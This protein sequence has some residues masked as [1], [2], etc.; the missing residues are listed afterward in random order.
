MALAFWVDSRPDGVAAAFAAHDEYLSIFSYF[1]NGQTKYMMTP[2]DQFYTAPFCYMPKSRKGGFIVFTCQV[3]WLHG[4]PL[5]ESE[6]AHHRAHEYMELKGKYDVP[7]LGTVEKFMT[8]LGLKERDIFTF[9]NDGCYPTKRDISEALED[10]AVE[11]TCAAMGWDI[12]QN[13]RIVRK[14]ESE[15]HGLPILNLADWDQKQRKNH[16][17]TNNNNDSDNASKKNASHADTTQVAQSKGD[18]KNNKQVNL[19]E[20]KKDSSTDEYQC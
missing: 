19:Q 17:H 13:W 11:V 1:A 10:K 14:K 12:P 2:N 5:G 20:E 7:H 16:K 4:N 6:R 15:T 9:T 3:P 18:E 8:T